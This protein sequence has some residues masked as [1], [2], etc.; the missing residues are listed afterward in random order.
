MAVNLNIIILKSWRYFYKAADT[1]HTMV[2]GSVIF[3][4][5]YY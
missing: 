5:I 2:D 4:C 1:R 3:I